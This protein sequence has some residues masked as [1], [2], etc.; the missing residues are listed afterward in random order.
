MSLM[1]RGPHHSTWAGKCGDYSYAKLHFMD[2]DRAPIV[3]GIQP[4][5]PNHAV[6]QAQ[7]NRV[8]PWVGRCPGMGPKIPTVFFVLC[9]AINGNEGLVR[10]KLDFQSANRTGSAP[11]DPQHTIADFVSGHPF[12]Q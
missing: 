4:S 10:L 12:F 9:E 5:G 1:L 2:H 8:T 11:Q 6:F 3:T 7:S